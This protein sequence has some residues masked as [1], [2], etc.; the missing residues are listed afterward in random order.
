MSSFDPKPQPAPGLRV[1]FLDFDAFFASVEQA[2]NPA[3]RG[4]PVAVV[5][6]LSNSS[7]CIAASY[8]AKRF[9]IKTGTNVGEA[10]RR[11]PQLVL[12][13]GRHERYIEYHHAL[14]AAVEDCAPVEQVASIDELWLALDAPHRSVAAARELARQV[15][16]SLARVAPSMTC[17]IGLAA[18]PYLAKLASDMDKPNGITVLESADLPSR[19][20]HLKLSDF[21]GIGPGMEARLRRY[22]IITVEALYAASR[23]ELRRIWGG[24]NGERFYDELR[25]LWA[26]RPSHGR[27]SISHSHV[28]PPTL[29]NERDAL[30]VLHRL[31]QKACVRLRA[32]HYVS[33]CLWVG[34]RHANRS[35]WQTQQRFDPTQD[36]LLL[37]QWLKQ[38]WQ[39]RP[40]TAPAPLRVGMALS[41]LV[42]AGEQSH[43]L[44][45]PERGRLWDGIDALNQRYGRNTV[46]LGGA[47]KTLD[48]APMRI[49]FTRI[50]D[51]RYEG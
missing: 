36:S 15:K 21:C 42:P 27:A 41:E 29:R 35:D 3:L 32:M 22:G 25:G 20:L 40:A 24:I 33:G 14:V 10:R 4:R 7:C 9:G 18:N 38:L 37:T 46:Y 39:Q 12:V 45:T 13:E 16:S 11:C 50:P 5:P 26:T 17:S 23:S 43:S 6:V 30:A 47:F 19:V 34:V 51:L 1:L 31:T 44:L 28:L 8:E 48:Q 49:A 2:E